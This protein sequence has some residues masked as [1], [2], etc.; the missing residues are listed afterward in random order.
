MKDIELLC[1]CGKTF[2]FS[3]KDQEFYKDMGF[4]KPK[5]CRDCRIKKKEDRKAKDTQKTVERIR[6]GDKI[7]LQ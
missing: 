1:G 7:T 2:I 5:R 3:V 6:S 4:D